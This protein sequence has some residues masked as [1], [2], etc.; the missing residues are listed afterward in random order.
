MKI[1]WN[2]KLRPTYLYSKNLK[3]AAIVYLPATIVRLIQ[4]ELKMF[5]K[6]QHTKLQLL[7]RCMQWLPSANRKSYDLI[8]W[9][10]ISIRM[11][12]KLTDTNIEVYVQRNICA[13]FRIR[14]GI[15]RKRARWISIYN[16]ISVV[17]KTL[18]ASPSRRKIFSSNLERGR[19][20]AHHK[21]PLRGCDLE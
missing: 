2:I 4:C 14:T 15:Y 17:E 16:R 6:W 21:R 9:S 19:C 3:F 1:C 5:I 13:R 10:R 8:C 7:M 20:A 12:D 18:F 11:D